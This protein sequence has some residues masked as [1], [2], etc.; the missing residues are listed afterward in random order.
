M[1]ERIRLR[2]PATVK[3][4]F[5]SEQRKPLHR[6]TVNL[7]LEKYANASLSV[8]AYPHMLRHSVTAT[9]STPSGIRPAIQRDS[10]SSGSDHPTFSLSHVVTNRVESLVPK[11]KIMPRGTINL[12]LSGAR[13]GAASAST[14]SPYCK[15]G[16][17]PPFT[18]RSKITASYFSGRQG[19]PRWLTA[20]TLALE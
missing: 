9:S 17:W 4:F 18:M 10:R 14:L 6:S 20:A 12:R 1:K 8:I 16:C 13:Q 19:P 15:R 2:V 11:C 3:T 7:L 5:V